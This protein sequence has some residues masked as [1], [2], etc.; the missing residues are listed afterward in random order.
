MCG[1]ELCDFRFNRGSEAGEVGVV[2][3]VVGA[4]FEELPQAFDEVQ[5]GRVP[6]QEFQRGSASDRRVMQGP[7]PRIVQSEKCSVQSAK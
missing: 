7:P 5:V 4:A 1:G 3:A 6:G 2:A